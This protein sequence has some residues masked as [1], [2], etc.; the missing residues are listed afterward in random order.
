MPRSRDT[1]SSNRTPL[2]AAH[3]QYPPNNPPPDTFSLP[4]TR[5]LTNSFV[6]VDHYLLLSSFEPTTH[7]H[8][9]SPSSHS[10]T[11]DR[12]L[13]TLHGNPLAIPRHRSK[14]RHKKSTLFAL[15]NVYM[16]PKCLT[17]PVSQPSAFNI[18]MT[19]SSPSPG[20]HCPFPSP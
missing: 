10:R 2:P 7:P 15:Q 19:P 17:P 3:K 5:P 14:G 12:T 20:P 13:D 1:S 11:G 4:T 18:I 6:C 16:T 8:I 9:L